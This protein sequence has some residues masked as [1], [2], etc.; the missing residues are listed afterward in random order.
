[1]NEHFPSEYR[2][3]RP[4]HT[5]SSTSSNPSLGLRVKDKARN[6]LYGS[7]TVLTTYIY[8]NRFRALAA[9]LSADADV[10]IITKCSTGRDRS[11]SMGKLRRVSRGKLGV[12]Y[13]Y[14]SMVIFTFALNDFRPLHKNEIGGRRS[15][16]SM[17]GSDHETSR[18]NSGLPMLSLRKRH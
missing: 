17:I 10:D 11:N 15:N 14:S 8:R 16:G 12:R 18:A 1:M 9:M 7:S 2:I 13:R 6:Q 3:V 5:E 4:L